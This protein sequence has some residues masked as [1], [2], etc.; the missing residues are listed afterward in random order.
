MLRRISVSVLMFAISFSVLFAKT[1]S[2]EE[3]VLVS[4]KFFSSIT[5]G[6]I[7][8]EVENVY[9]VETETQVLYHIINLKPQGW[10]MVAGDDKAQ[11]ILG[12]SL[13]SDY[14]PLDKLDV[15]AKSWFKSY[16]EQLKLQIENNKLERNPEW[17]VIGSGFKTTTASVD[18]LI[19]VEWN[20][21]SGWNMFCPVDETG[22]GGR[23]YVGC[24]AVAMAQAM[25]YYKYPESPMG[26]HGYNHDDYGTL[27]VNY[28]YEPDYNW[29]LMSNT[30]PDTL[31]AR[32]LYHLAV[33]V[34]MGFG[35][36][37]SG[38][39]TRDAKNSL[40]EYFGYSNKMKYN[41]RGDN[42]SIWKQMVIDELEAG[43]PLIYDGDA[44]DGKS[45]HA[46]NIDGYNGDFFHLNWGWSGSMNGYFTLNNLAPGTS[47]FTQGH[48]AIT[49]IRPVIPGPTDI[50]LSKT[51]V[52]ENL[53]LGSYVG[54]I[55]I[56]DEIDTNVYSYKCYGEKN[57][58][59]GYMTSHF[60][61]EN[62]SL[63]TNEL[64][65]YDETKS[66]E[67]KIDVTDM[68][69]N[70][71]TKTFTIDIIEN[72]TSSSGGNPTNSVEIVKVS[73]ILYPNP[74]SDFISINIG[75]VSNSAKVIIYNMSGLRIVEED[76]YEG[77]SEIDIRSLPMGM[78]VAYVRSNN[79]NYSTKFIKK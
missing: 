5:S 65:S 21:S 23:V 52:K 53:P 24:V 30:S 75:D 33:S 55:S 72:D 68:F 7:N 11:P 73:D 60:Y 46:F 10:V 6:S 2:K 41:E 31:N 17:D 45:G 77:N 79:I 19:P 57:L 61:I 18:P 8:Y 22:P 58:L 74:S 3:A 56:E 62:D 49:G 63:K 26:S 25:S 78:Y 47:D 69:E 48:G 32:L 20:Q 67:L 43:R 9:T 28:D 15:N 38:A 70:T 51:S 40:V 54:D 27:F 34:D 4:Q 42:D 64:I 76:I 16:E 59:G 14:V 12:Y 29:D 37:G 13:K 44:G 50:L 66:L 39:Y 35:P 71:F 36:D 1:V